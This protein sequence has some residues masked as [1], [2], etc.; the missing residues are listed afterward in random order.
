M[1][2]RFLLLI[3]VVM[4][5]GSCNRAPEPAATA[6][7]T[8]AAATPDKIMEQCQTLR[9]A[10]DASI[11]QSTGGI[12]EAP[13]GIR[14]GD[15]VDR[16]RAFVSTAKGSKV[17]LFPTWVGKGSNLRG[18]LWVKGDLMDFAPKAIGGRMEVKILVPAPTDS[19]MFM[20]TVTISPTSQKDWFTASLDAD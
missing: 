20:D 7:A 14:A 17:V 3:L 9:N 8:T 16:G 2:T 5:A 4:V 6:P 18:Y 1:C 15:V 19:G 11:Q 13:A 12:I 10:L